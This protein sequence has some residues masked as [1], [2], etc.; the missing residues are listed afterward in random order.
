MIDKNGKNDVFFEVNWKDKVDINNCQVVKVTLGEKEAYIK[1]D[2][3]NAFLFAIGRE[4]DQQKMIPQKLTK[5]RW[6]ETVVGVKATK[7]IRKGEQI[8]FPI[9]LSLPAVEKEIIGDVKKRQ[10]NIIVPR[11]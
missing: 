1:R 7:D 4:E 2:E 10:S 11:I 8:N 9:K 5:V 3:L 6:Y